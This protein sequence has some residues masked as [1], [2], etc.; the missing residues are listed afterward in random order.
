MAE[1]LYLYP[2]WLRI[3][4]G[5][6]ALLIIVLIVT[7]ISLQYSNTQFMI[8]PFDL[9]VTYHNLAGIVVSVNYFFFVIANIL[10]GNVRFY[11]LELKGLVQNLIRQSMYYL[12]GMFKGESSPY[13]V[14]RDRKFNPLQKIAYIVVMY[15]LL[16]L[17]IISGIALLFPETIVPR[18]FGFSGIQLTALLHSA[19]G[20]GIS[21]FLIIHVYISTTGKPISQ[22]FKS[23]MT[24]WH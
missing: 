6:N 24:G 11:R 19:V 18:V 7:G 2:L 4:H 14:T 17:V 1:K 15:V 8:I 13:P 16:P 21:L 22:N 10:S 5:I 23:I 20:F 12:L 3:W 9:S